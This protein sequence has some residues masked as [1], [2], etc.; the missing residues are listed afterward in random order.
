MICYYKLNTSSYLD[1]ISYTEVDS[2]NSRKG[3]EKQGVE[4]QE[5][6]KKKKAKTVETC[7]V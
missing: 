5:K 3:E 6:K 4:A 2:S 1:K 7:Q